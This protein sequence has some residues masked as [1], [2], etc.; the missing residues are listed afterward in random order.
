MGR[1]EFDDFLNLIDQMIDTSEPR[2]A[3]Y[4]RGYRRGIQLHQLATL[5]GTVQEHY[6]LQ[7]PYAD[8]G[9]QYLNAYARGYRDGCKGL[10]PSP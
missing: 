7:D 2:R 9:D 8:S 3:E 5:E 4:Y 1:E 10:K 6:Q